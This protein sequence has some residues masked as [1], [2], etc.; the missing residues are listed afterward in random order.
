[1][2]TPT[3][4]QVTN[5]TKLPQAGDDSLVLG[6][7][8]LITFAELL[9]NDKGGKSISIYQVLTDQN[10]VVN[11]E[12]GTIEYVGVAPITDVTLNF[13]YIIQMGKGALSQADV[14]VN[15]EGSGPGEGGGPGN[16]IVNG[17]F[18]ELTSG[19][20]DDGWG[21]FTLPGWTNENGGTIEIWSTPGPVDGVAA[22]DGLQLLEVDATTTFDGISQTIATLDDQSYTLSFEMAARPNTSLGTNTL[23]VYW[24][25][26]LIDTI[27]PADYEWQT[28]SYQV[29]DL[30]DDNS[31]K[32]TFKEVSSENDSLGILIDNVSLFMV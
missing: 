17:S 5:A 25:G 20:F 3:P 8:G 31:A 11:Y 10:W 30:Q 6:D 7:D 29:Q 16:L 27:S 19:V 26:Q 4:S 23:E 32:L 15:I 24:D 2:T 9:A 22:P 12:A 14:E 21:N 18:E 1:M 28:Y 13:S